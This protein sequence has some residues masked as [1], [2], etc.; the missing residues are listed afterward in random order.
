MNYC[1]IVV[2]D[3]R[4]ELAKTDFVEID[5]RAECTTRLLHVI[6]LARQERV[7]STKLN[8]GSDLVFSKKTVGTPSSQ[9]LA[10]GKWF[11]WK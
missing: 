4:Q 2:C 11:W 6:A 7:G 10:T 9:V 1:E 5:V 8:T 3:D